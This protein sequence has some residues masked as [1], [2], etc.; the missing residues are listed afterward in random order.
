[1]QWVLRDRFF[2]NWDGES[3]VQTICEHATNQALEGRGDWDVLIS[4]A[5]RM[6]YLLREKPEPAHLVWRFLIKIGDVHDDRCGAQ[7]NFDTLEPS[8][9]M[10][11]EAVRNIQASCTQCHRHL[12]L[13]YELTGHLEPLANDSES[14]IAQLLSL[15]E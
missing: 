14:L 5:E 2:H 4:P 1:M 8:F 7:L 13:D 11:L 10:L 12:V 6:L 3:T 9:P 15:L